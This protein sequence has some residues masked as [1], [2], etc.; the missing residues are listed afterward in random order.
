MYN[1]ANLYKVIE[2]TKMN[3]I[4]AMWVIVI[5]SALYLMVKSNQRFRM[6]ESQTP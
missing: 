5:S 2:E 4:T 3:L 6:A 1:W